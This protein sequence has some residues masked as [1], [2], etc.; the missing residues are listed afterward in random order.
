M[1]AAGPE[2]ALRDVKDKALR[3]LLPQGSIRLASAV[4][5]WYNSADFWYLNIVASSLTARERQKSG[6][7]QC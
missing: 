3:K 5:A 4:F 2:T 1:L 7:A 6:W